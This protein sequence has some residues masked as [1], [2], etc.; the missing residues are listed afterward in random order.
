MYAGMIVIK[1]LLIFKY[2]QSHKSEHR[3]VRIYSINIRNLKVIFLLYPLVSYYYMMINRN[4]IYFTIWVSLLVAVPG[5]NIVSGGFMATT[6]FDFYLR[7]LTESIAC[8]C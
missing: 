4:I 6:S 5:I 3:H 7:G 1:Y 8:S 2:V